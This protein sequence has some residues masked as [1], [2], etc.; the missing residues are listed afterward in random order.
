MA[1]PKR[2]LHVHQVKISLHEADAVE[3]GR[4]AQASGV[5]TGTLVRGLARQHLTALRRVATF[6]PPRRADDIRAKFSSHVF[7]WLADDEYAP[8][9]RAAATA[10][11]TVSS[12]LGR[13]I[14]E[15]WLRMRRT[16]QAR[17]DAPLKQTN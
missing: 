5:G 13:H 10:G 8:L 7:V 14:V 15:P 17:A 9:Q 12:Y 1:S 16:R 11:C 4:C 2:Q 3:I 6:A